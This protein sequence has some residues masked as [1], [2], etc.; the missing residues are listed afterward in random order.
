M[1]PFVC[2]VCHGSG[3]IPVRQEP[4]FTTT[5]PPPPELCKPCRGNG[6]VWGPPARDITPPSGSIEARPAPPTL[7]ETFG[8]DPNAPME[9]KAQ[10][11]EAE[12]S[13]E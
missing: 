11:A 7:K 3:E 2:P 1:R 13:V 4:G 5:A 9:I 6:I 10:K 12:A 8:I